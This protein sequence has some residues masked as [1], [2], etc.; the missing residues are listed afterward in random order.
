MNNL[1]THTYEGHR[2]HFRDDG[3]FNMTKAAK[4]Y[5]KRLDHFFENASTAAYIEVLQDLFPGI[6]PI[7]AKR[8]NGN[9]PTVGT[10]G[11]PKLAVFFA[12]WL[13]TKFELF[14][15]MVIDDILTG[16]AEL[17][18]LKPVESSALKMSHSFPEALR[19]AAE[20]AEQE[21]RL[22]SPRK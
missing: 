14:C 4:A 16:K 18:I 19:L 8:G 13:D 22:S 15:S 17:T 2:Y 11:H 12:Q 21:E 6:Q 3:Y 7:K 9:L 1:I 5:G 10:W 20:L